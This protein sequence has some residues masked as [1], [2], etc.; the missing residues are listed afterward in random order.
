MPRRIDSVDTV[1]GRVREGHPGDSRWAQARVSGGFLRGMMY[2]DRRR[3]KST[4]SISDELLA[5][6]HPALALA[7]GM[8]FDSSCQESMDRI[9]LLVISLPLVALA[10]AVAW[11]YRPYKEQEADGRKVRLHPPLGLVALREHEGARHKR[12]THVIFRVGQVAAWA[13][14]LQ[15]MSSET[16]PFRLH[17]S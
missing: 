9:F 10:A 17:V 1:L 3:C 5:A 15:C 2:R 4:A 14:C 8:C 7:A 6:A 11:T 16:S 12:S 13:S